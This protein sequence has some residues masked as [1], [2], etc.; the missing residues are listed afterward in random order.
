MK[1]IILLMCVTL[2][3]SINAQVN[4]YSKPA[5]YSEPTQGYKIDY[6]QL[7]NAVQKRENDY[8][9]NK[10]KLENLKQWIYDLK[11]KI[12]ENQFNVDI[13][14]AKGWIDIYLDN[15]DLSTMEREDFKT[16]ENLIEKSISNYETRTKNATVEKEN[17]LNVIWEDAKNQ[18]T[19]GNHIESIEFLN[20]I[21]KQNPNFSGS[22]FYLTNNYL[23]IGDLKNAKINF[24]IFKSLEPTN[25]L[26][27][28]LGI[29]IAFE[30]GNYIEVI[31]NANKVIESEP[32]NFSTYLTR[33]RAKSQLKDYY[34]S[35]KDYEKAI[36]LKP[37]F[38][39]AYNN[40]SWNNF[41]Q[42]KY[43]EALI[44]S[45]KAIELDNQNDVAFDSRA[46]IKFA[47]KDYKGC[48]EDSKA[49]LAINPK[50][51]NP[52]FLLGRANYRLGNKQI[53]CENWSKAGELGKIEAYEYISKYCQ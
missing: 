10:N 50:Q 24:E 49:S 32:N 9:K 30:E 4:R 5:E 52:Y 15:V 2:S 3:I 47:L 26:V 42:E 39:M 51:S 1:P 11:S 34:G 7:N 38:S 28:K 16:L 18:Y 23:S 44:N 12:T 46:D 40:I 35:T 41:L 43:T 45:N 53:A 36:E 14:E 37:D 48:I 17:N 13:D 8:Q 19:K 22:Y 33:G 25:I 31:K 27:T 29:S 20:I 21:T 6:N